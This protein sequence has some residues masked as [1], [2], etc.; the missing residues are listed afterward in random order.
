MGLKEEMKNEACLNYLLK[1]CERIKMSSKED[2]DFI[3]KIQ[4]EFKNEDLDQ[5][6]KKIIQLNKN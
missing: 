1:L 3:L 5:N 6:I 4:K 2:V